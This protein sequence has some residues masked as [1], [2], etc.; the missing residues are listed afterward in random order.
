[1]RRGGASIAAL[2]L[3]L[4]AVI[5]TSVITTATTAPTRGGGGAVAPFVWDIPAPFP[6]PPVPHDNPMSSHTVE[7]GRHLFYDTRLSGNGRQS[8]ATC[9]R[10]ELAFTDGRARA[11]GSTGM[12]HPRG[13]MSLANIGYAPA[14][15]WA[16]PRVT[17]LEEQALV[18][19]FGTSPVELGLDPDG[20]SLLQRVRA[21][22]VYQRLFAQAF[23]ADSAPFSVTN[24]VRALGAF[25]R[26]LVSMRS[27]YDRYRYGRDRNAISE[28]A[29]RGEMI[30]FS[31]QR[32]GCFQCHGGWNFSGAVR[33]D[34]DTTVSA[35]FFNTGLYNVAGAVSYPSSNTGLHAITGRI[36]DVGRF[37]APTLRNIAVTAPYMHDGSIAT[38]EAVVDHY[39][40]GGRTIASGP[41]AGV[42]RD[43]R[44]KSPSVHGFVLTGT[45]RQD[46]VAFLEALTDS[47]FLRNPAF[48]NPWPHEP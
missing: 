44:Y 1:M 16:D 10:Q 4:G 29:K 2:L 42:G 18:P 46:L 39:A 7:L 24:I 48:A 43:N 47:V 11:V 8:C 35:G 27:P 37:R 14:L 22:D 31:G 23:P 6:R 25:E 13:S 21:D 15:T 36:E 33:Y 20:A 45:D 40:A 19:M 3:L 28:S 38:L 12:M 5:T 41:Q 34:G 26:T 17:A 9:H 32:G 30:F